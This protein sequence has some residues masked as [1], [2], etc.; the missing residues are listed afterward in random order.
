MISQI[1]QFVYIFLLQGHKFFKHFANFEASKKNFSL[2]KRRHDTQHNDIQHN[3]IQHNDIQH[4]DIQHNDTQHND[5]Q[6]NEI[7]NND[8]QHNNIQQNDTRQN[9]TAIM[10]SVAFCLSLC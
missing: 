1:L 4:N 8:I 9:D 7:Q 3:D 10:L 2:A 5:I 6:H